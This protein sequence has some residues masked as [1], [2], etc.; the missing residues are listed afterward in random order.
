MCRQVFNNEQCE[1]GEVHFL[2][3]T[4]GTVESIVADLDS[5]LN[6]KNVTNDRHRESLSLA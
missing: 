2:L 1:G 3:T 4:D 6:L 5:V